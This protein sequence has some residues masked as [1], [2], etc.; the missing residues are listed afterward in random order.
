M[1]ITGELSIYRAAELKTELLLALAR[2]RDELALDLSGVTDIDVAGLQVLLALQV[3]AHATGRHLQL[4]EP[5]TPVQDLFRLLDVGGLFE[6]CRL[7][8]ACA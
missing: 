6:A 5:S 3:E 7:A 2:E 4:I 1:Q 8:P